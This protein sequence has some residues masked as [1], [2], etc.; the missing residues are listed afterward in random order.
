MAVL[1]VSLGVPASPFSRRLANEVWLDHQ[2]P[3][4]SSLSLPRM[5]FFCCFALTLAF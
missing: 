1:D 5:G 4:D 2:Q 3:P